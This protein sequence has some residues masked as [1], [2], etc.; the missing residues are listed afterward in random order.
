MPVARLA[1][2]SI[3]TENLAASE[4]FY[5]EV[6]GFRPGYRPP[7]G[8][9]GRWLYAGGDEADYGI[10]HLIDAG[11][12]ERL[13]RYLGARE[14]STGA[15]ALDHIAFFATGWRDMRARL[16][17]TRV[18]FRECDVPALGLHQIFLLDP[19]GITIELNYPADEEATH[20]GCGR[21]PRSANSAISA[22]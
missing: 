6:M 21:L 14:M 10:V 16:E 15:G 17:R 11:G 18:P 2:Y 8:F 20:A 9:P 3:R 12:G 4:T 13:D 1:H 19:N 5:T 7:F 22:G